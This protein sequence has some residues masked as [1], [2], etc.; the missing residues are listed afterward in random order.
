MKKDI[1]VRKAVLEDVPA[2]VEL[3]KELMD[4]NKQY[5]ERFTLS[6][7]DHDEFISFINDC[8]EDKDCH[9]LVAESDESIVGYCVSLIRPCIGPHIQ[10]YGH[11]CN[12]CVSSKYQNK[13]IGKKLSKE[14]LDWFQQN[15]ISH[16]E[17]CVAIENNSA[18]KF[19]T[20]MGFTPYVK[21]LCLEI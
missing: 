18:E 4:I 20:K 19:Y 16:V 14:T 11:I 15:G 6:E 2:I 21:T 7:A 8:A 3:W 17:V 12:L 5:D 13:G 1:A 9:I 10:R